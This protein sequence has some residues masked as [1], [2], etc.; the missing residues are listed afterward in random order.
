MQFI[1]SRGGKKQYNSNRAFSIASS[2]LIFYMRKKIGSNET[3]KRPWF[4]HFQFLDNMATFGV[5][6]NNSVRSFMH[7][8]CQFPI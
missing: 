5:G 4:G 1:A 8:E 7:E 3:K 6:V 2:K